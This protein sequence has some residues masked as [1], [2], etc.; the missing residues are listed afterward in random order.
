MR[1]DG[2]TL[3]G[4]I[5]R[6]EIRSRWPRLV[7]IALVVTVAGAT[8]LVAGMGARR[9]ATSFERRAAFANVPDGSVA[10]SL[11]GVREVEDAQKRSVV[12][13][14]RDVARSEIVWGVTTALT[15]DREV[16]TH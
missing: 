14:Q 1:A 7:L 12:D 8:V 11:D 3:L 13:R 4:A 5:T 9:T 6:A 16:F 10:G 2:W 15:S